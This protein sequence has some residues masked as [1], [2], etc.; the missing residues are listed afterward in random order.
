M[1]RNEIMAITKEV[2]R[3]EWN[4]QK[5]FPTQLSLDEAVA[6]FVAKKYEVYGAECMEN[7]PEEGLRKVCT[8]WAGLYNRIF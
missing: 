8:Y 2:F 4:R 7:M 1:T 3:D 5:Y 6:L